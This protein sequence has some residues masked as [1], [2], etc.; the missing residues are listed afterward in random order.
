MADE[1]VEV[2]QPL[3]RSK[4]SNANKDLE[5]LLFFGPY[6]IAVL[7]VYQVATFTFAFNLLYM[8]FVG[9]EPSWHCQAVNETA[10]LVNTTFVDRCQRLQNGQCP[11]ITWSNMS[12]SSIVSEWNLICTNRYVVYLIITIQMVGLL[13]GAP[14]MTHIA[15]LCGRKS[16]LLACIAGQSVSGIGTGFSPTWQV[17]AVS[18]FFV[19]LFGGGLIPIAGVYL[20]E[21]VNR[22]N[23]MLFMSFGGVNMGFLLS[24]C[25]AFLFQHWSSLT[26]AANSLGFVAVLIL[27][28]VS[29]TPRWLI[30]HGKVEQSR[31][32]YRY[33]LRMNRKSS[34]QMNDNEWEALLIQIMRHTNRRR[35]SFVHLFQTRKV[36]LRTV[37][38]TFS[39]F[40]LNVIT[41]VLMLSMTDLAGSIYLNAMIYGFVLW[42]SAVLS[43]LVDRFLRFVGRR[44]MIGSLLSVICICLLAMCISKWLGKIVHFILSGMTVCA[45]RWKPIPWLVL[46]FMSLA[47]M[48]SFMA[49]VPE[50]KGRPL[51]EEFDD[52]RKLKLASKESGNT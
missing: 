7:I 2:T 46:A 24:A 47:F 5:S 26:I 32:S 21:S 52:G 48:V 20:V 12:F 37:V 15:D 11:N 14:L 44:R 34:E 49:V 35:S 36:S 13:F 51:V 16:T 38:L 18:R 8:T 43:S 42:G 9:W 6:Q 39:I 25:M 19:G 30:Q 10:Q 50:T 41:T 27:G 1:K 45:Q 3:Q 28:F 31:K 22:N 17:F 40:V 23:R 33:I 29:E 4:G